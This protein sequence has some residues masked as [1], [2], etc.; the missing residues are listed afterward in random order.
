MN[1]CPHCGVE[2]DAS[3]PGGLCPACL[4]AGGLES[5]VTIRSGNE[6][7]QPGVPE[8]VEDDRFGPYRILRLIGEGG[9]GS[10]YLAEQ[11]HPIQRQVALKVVKLGMDTRQV[12]TRFE[13]ERQ[14]LALMDHP[15]IAHVYEAGS[16]DRG[17]P[18][19]VMEY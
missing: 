14:A 6:V 1:R 13:S 12:V 8:G 18:Y 16:S 2:L 7:E 11:S 5:Q 4:M 19:F 9:M 10:V 3:S 15:N 17:R